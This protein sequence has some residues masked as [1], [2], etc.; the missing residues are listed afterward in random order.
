LIMSDD[1]NKPDHPADGTYLV[2]LAV[3]AVGIPNHIV[4]R[5]RAAAEAS[6]PR[7]SWRLHIQREAPE[8]FS[9]SRARND[10]ILKLAGNCSI[11]VCTDVDCLVPPGLIDFTGE[12]VAD[13]RA[14][15]VLC[16][17]VF[18]PFGDDVSGPYPWEHW[19]TLPLR[20][21]GTGSWVAM[22]T[23]DWFYVGGWDERLTGWGGEDD[24]LR[25]RRR[26]AGIQTMEVTS[27][28]LV[29]VNHPPRDPDQRYGR[30]NYQLGLSLP[31][32]N[33]LLEKAIKRNRSDLV[34]RFRHIVR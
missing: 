28:P 24:V 9:R 19:Q 29:H 31:P 30:R 17:D 32:R 4:A 5:F 26:Q 23:R 12:N 6:S 16:R 10:A 13:G 1:K 8:G 27:F 25:V 34:E 33:F 21:W 7:C 18:W 22:T 15:W 14:V 2:G 20:V 11:I 3:G